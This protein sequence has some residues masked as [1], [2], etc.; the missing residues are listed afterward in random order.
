[1]ADA[2]ELEV[3]YKARLASADEL[4][5]RLSARVRDALEGFPHI[6]RI[7]FRPKSLGSFLGKAGALDDAGKRKYQEPLREI[8]DQI[9]GRVIVFF[10]R[11]SRASHS[12]PPQRAGADRSGA[13]GASRR[14]RVRL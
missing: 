4:C 1:M 5:T 6:D 14:R 13:Q 9:A 3:L 8:E 7:A 11:R 12:S 10:P 2:V